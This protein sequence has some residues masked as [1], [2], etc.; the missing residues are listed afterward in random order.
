M[1]SV[2][3]VLSE[4]VTRRILRRLSTLRFDPMPNSRLS[5]AGLRAP[6]GPAAALAGAKHAA[7]F[8]LVLGLS[9]CAS[10]DT[11]DYKQR[12]TSSLVYPF[13]VTF[14]DEV[15]YPG[16][17]LCGT[18]SSSSDGGLRYVKGPFIVTPDRVMSHPTPTERAVYCSPQP[19]EALMEETR[20]GGPNTD[21]KALATIRDDMRAIDGAIVRFQSSQHILPRQLEQLLETGF[22][23]G[24]DTI[25]DPWKRTYSYAPGLSGRSTP[26]YDLKTLGQ[27]GEPGG[28]GPDADV[29]KSHLALIEHVLRIKGF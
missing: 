12:L 19:V 18:Y 24:A 21:W 25:Q 10:L 23:S 3:Y 14:E 5:C 1:R 20:I 6:R 28:A 27:D 16:R 2:S 15:T 7:L 11:D 13:G 17:V 9:A 22:I 29:D 26:R 4:K 8:F